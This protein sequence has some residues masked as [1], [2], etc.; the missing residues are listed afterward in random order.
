MLINEPQG[1]ARSPVRPAAPGTVI[2]PIRIVK[3]LH[4]LGE[5]EPEKKSPAS[6]GQLAKSRDW[7]L[8]PSSTV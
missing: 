8:A 7:K 1:A 4:L 5:S 6:S 2:N 3:L